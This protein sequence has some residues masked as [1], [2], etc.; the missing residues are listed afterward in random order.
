MTKLPELRTSETV[1]VFGH[2][3]IG[4]DKHDAGRLHLKR[5]PSP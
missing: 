4:E 2:G 5:I 3:P 1:T